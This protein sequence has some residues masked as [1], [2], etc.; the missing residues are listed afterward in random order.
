MSIGRPRVEGSTAVCHSENDRE[1]TER[2]KVK[3]RTI[4]HRA[5]EP[6]HS[7]AFPELDFLKANLGSEV[8]W[9]NGG[10][11]G[12]CCIDISAVYPPRT[13]WIRR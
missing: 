9:L 6:D 8:F 3:R 13:A 10:F 5:L 11:Y 1:R 4:R 12:S 7:L 2:V